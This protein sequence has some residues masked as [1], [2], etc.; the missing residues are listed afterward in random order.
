[1]IELASKRMPGAHLYQGDFTQDLVEPLLGRQYDHIVATYS[2]HHLTDGQ[3]PAFLCDLRDRLG[4]GG[5][6]LI[7]DVMFRTRTKLIECRET[8]NDRWDSEENFV[9]DELRETF[10]NLSFV[11][12]SF[13]AGIIA[14]P[15]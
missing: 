2:L 12:V 11:Q 1:M 15:G 10:P 5:K 14:L 13:C 8:V 6:V 7:G 3:K 9:V 4:E